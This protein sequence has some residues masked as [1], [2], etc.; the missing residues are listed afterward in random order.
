MNEAEVMGL[1]Q[2]LAN[3]NEYVKQARQGKLLHYVWDFAAQVKQD[4]AKVAVVHLL[5]GEE[6][7]GPPGTL[8]SS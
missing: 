4:F 3:L 2:G 8:P 7:L 5:H 6:Q 1:G